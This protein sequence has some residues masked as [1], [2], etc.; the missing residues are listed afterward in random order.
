MYSLMTYGIPHL[1]IPVTADGEIKVKNHLEYLKMWQ[2]QVKYIKQGKLDTTLLP[3]PSDVLFGRGKPIREHTGNLR[4]HA[5]VEELSP[6]YK[7]ATPNSEKAALVDEV[8]EMVKGAPG[9]FLSKDC[10]IW[11]EVDDAMARDKVVRLFRTQRRWAKQRNDQEMN[12]NGGATPRGSILD[13]QS[14]NKRFKI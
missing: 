6:R 2:T 12:G 9:R 5:I 8:L 11:L 10:G 14:T 1:L 4:F 7:N 13:G 3:L